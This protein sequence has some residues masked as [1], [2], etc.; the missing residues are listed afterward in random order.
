M[1]RAFTLL[2]V[3]VSVV[4]VFMIGMTLTQISSQ[5]VNVLQSVKDDMNSYDSAILYTTNEYRDL[6]SYLN[7]AE[8]PKF[9]VIVERKSLDLSS[10]AVMITK[11]FIISYNISKDRIK[12]DDETKAYYRIK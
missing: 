10:D 2:E 6:N 11:D 1:N 9:E 3:L 8:A 5:N 12:I 7:I 4:I